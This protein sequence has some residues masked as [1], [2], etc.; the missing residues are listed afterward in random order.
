MSVVFNGIRDILNYA[1][2]PVNRAVTALETIASAIPSE[3]EI[4]K[5][6]GESKT[7]TLFELTGVDLASAP[8]SKYDSKVN[9]IISDMGTSVV[10]VTNQPQP[11]TINFGVTVGNAH[12]QG[13]FS[14]NTM[15]VS[16][17]L[18]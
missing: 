9:D 4:A 11:N 3:R 16:G 12:I 6:L 15:V 14:S 2:K 17:T 5:R 1:M 13:I 8:P 7:N 10:T 18:S